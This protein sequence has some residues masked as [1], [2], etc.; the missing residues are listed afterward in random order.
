MIT[1]S[2]GIILALSALYMTAGTG[3][4][5]CLKSGKFNLGGE[6]QIYAGGFVCA[7]IL[8]AFGKLGPASAIGTTDVIGSTGASSTAGIPAFFAITLAFLA[9]ATVSTLLVLISTLLEKKRGASFLLTSFIVSSAI[10]PLVDGLIAGPFKGSGGNLIATNYIIDK[11]Q[12]PFIIPSL[13]LSPYFFVAIILCI[14][15]GL[16]I[17]RTSFGKEICIYGQA[18]EFALYTGLS[19]NSILYSATAASGA[20]NGITGAAAVMGTYFFCSPGFYSGI[21]WNALAVAMI[22]RLNPFFVIPSSIFLATLTT[23][24]DQYALFHNF[25]F[26]ISGLIQALII[27]AIA[28]PL[29]LPNAKNPLRSKISNHTKT[30]AFQLKSR[31]GKK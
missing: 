19:E 31:G 8:D 3:N 7:I 12:F 27:F 14:A 28:F 5:I 15:G 30:A 16:F 18:K 24:A 17:F 6:G 22:A 26:D 29:V 25:D 2:I 21:G 13:S 10:I 4:A 23:A 9:A 11:Y 1:Y 20:L